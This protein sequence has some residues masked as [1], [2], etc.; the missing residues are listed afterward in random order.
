MAWTRGVFH[1]G[2]WI[3]VYYPPTPFSLQQQ[4]PCQSGERCCFRNS[5]DRGSAFFWLS[6]KIE[7]LL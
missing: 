1:N 6:M 5:W 3:A 4:R 7:F 2:K